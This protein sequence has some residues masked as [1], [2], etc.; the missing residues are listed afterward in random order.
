MSLHFAGVNGATAG[1][2]LSHQNMF[3]P[4]SVDVVGVLIPGVE[5]LAMYST[6]AVENG[7]GTIMLIG[8]IAQADHYIEYDVTNLQL[9][10]TA[11]MDCSGLPL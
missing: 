9:G 3:V 6:A 11:S 7:T 1:F 4:A 5:C 8:N 10:W 2:H